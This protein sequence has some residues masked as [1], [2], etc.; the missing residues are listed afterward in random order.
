M[1]TRKSKIS[2]P[3]FLQKEKLRMN[4]ADLRELEDLLSHVRPLMLVISQT[5]LRSDDLKAQLQLHEYWKATSE[6]RDRLERASRRY[7]Q[8]EFRCIDSARESGKQACEDR[9]ADIRG[10]NQGRR[11]QSH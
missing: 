7:R 1:N 9:N 10:Q 8:A 6:M 3:T 5:K 4:R 2:R 11:P